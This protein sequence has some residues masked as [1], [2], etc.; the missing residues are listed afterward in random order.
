MSDLNLNEPAATPTPTPTPTSEV[1]ELRRA[2]EQLQSETF[3]LRLVLLVVVGALTLFFWRE[4]G[5]YKFEATQMQPQVMQANQVLD[6]LQKQGVSVETQMQIFQN[7]VTR[8][9]EYG[10]THPDYAQILAKYGVPVAAT[11]AA[12]PAKK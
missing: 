1:A 8:L 5:V 6:A 12:N 7:V 2:C 4:A 9:T 10:R 11:P 3:N